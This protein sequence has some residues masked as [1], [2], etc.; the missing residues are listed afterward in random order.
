MG[1]IK[2]I[3]EM[4][5]V[6]ALAKIPRV[7]WYY[8]TYI[9]VWKYIYSGYYTDWHDISYKTIEGAKRRR[10][11]QMNAAKALCAELAGLVF[12]EKCEINI[13]GALQDYINGVF[14]DNYFIVNMQNLI[15]KSF[16]LGG[17]ALKVWVEHGKV[18]IDYVA[19]DCFIP[20]AW[21]N[22][23]VSEA[24]FVH[25]SVRENHYFT[26][27]EWHLWEHGTYVVRNQLYKSDSPSTLGLSIPLGSMYPELQEEA[28]IE[29]LKCPLFVYFK[30]NI[31]NNLFDGSPL[32]ISVFANAFDTLKAL[33]VCLDSFTREFTLGKKRIIVPESA[34]RL[35]QDRNGGGVVRYFDASDEVYV[36]MHN[37]DG[38]SFKIQD[39][40]IEIRFEE[41]IK[42]IDAFLSI[43]ALQTGLTA[44]T[45]AFDNAQGLKTATEV[46]S[47]NSKTFKT[48]KSHENIISEAIRQL[49]EAVVSVSQLYDM[50][51]GNLE[52]EISIVFDDSIVDDKQTKINTAL[53][54]TASGLLS[55]ETALV[56]YLGYTEEG[57]KE[58]IARINAENQSVTAENID[59]FNNE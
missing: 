41:H 32:G 24:V 48:V 51:Q 38:E 35:V 57:A 55:K 16:A 20:I 59:Y 26:M 58:E 34:V 43:L 15:E 21:D 52:Y 19:A 27:L 22:R 14:D 25:K 4:S 5:D 1:I 45:L 17:A 23:R 11:A 31:A 30:P 29:S 33:D 7:D 54:L 2:E 50:I 13:T 8:Q 6:F 36:A 28:R 3:K 12:N 53:Q 37:E 10:M 44:G 56:K 47:E 39:N 46:I 49:V 40:T 42:S 18:K 9:N